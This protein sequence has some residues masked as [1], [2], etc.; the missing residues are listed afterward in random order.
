VL[1]ILILPVNFHK[2]GLFS[3]EFWMKIFRQEKDF[4][5]IF[6]SPKFKRQL[7]PAPG[8]DPTESRYRRP[9]RRAS[10]IASQDLDVG[11]EVWWGRVS[12]PHWERGLGGDSALSPDTCWIL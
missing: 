1:R 10:G 3:F 2:I 11:Y 5:T 8:H 4:P 12:P 9:C 7:P 6:D